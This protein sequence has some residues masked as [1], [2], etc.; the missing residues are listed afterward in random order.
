MVELLDTFSII[1]TAF[2]CKNDF[3][4]GFTQEKFEHLISSNL[5]DP[6]IDLWRGVSIKEVM[7]CNYKK[8]EVIQLNRITSF[9]EDRK[10]AES[11]S[12]DEYGTHVI[13]KLVK[14]KAFN[15]TS[16]S[17]KVMSQM[18]ERSIDHN[19]IDYLQ[20]QQRMVEEELEWMVSGNTK[21]L[22]KSI[23]YRSRFDPSR[24]FTIVELE[25]IN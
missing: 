14:G 20:D 21:Y 8:G 18:I 6:C 7:G 1:S 25:I 22:I 16:L 13:F 10:I 11:F 19:E 23:E 24:E 4:K 12:S 2:I 5:E 17:S 3:N 9:T 15:Y